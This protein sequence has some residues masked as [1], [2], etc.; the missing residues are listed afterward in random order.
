MRQTD[1]PGKPSNFLL[2]LSL[3]CCCWPIHQF[4]FKNEQ[5]RMTF[6][7]ACYNERALFSPLFQS[8]RKAGDR[9]RY[10]N[11]YNI[12]GSHLRRCNGGWRQKVSEEQYQSKLGIDRLESA[13]DIG[14][15][16]LSC[17]A[18]CMI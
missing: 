17:L 2:C 3:P 8:L 1:E 10:F 9:W 15:G 7:E 13:T 4:Y 14:N 11:P 16:R 6:V 5:L 12:S 18:C